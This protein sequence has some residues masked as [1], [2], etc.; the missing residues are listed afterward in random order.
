MVLLKK[1]KYKSK[2]DIK[3]EYCLIK[4]KLLLELKSLSLLKI[5]KISKI[6][7]KKDE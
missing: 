6:N 1:I 5:K 7:I 4:D 3:L 2:I